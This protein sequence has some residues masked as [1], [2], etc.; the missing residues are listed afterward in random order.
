MSQT[1]AIGQYLS[2]T[3]NS[4]GYFF[5]NFYVGKEALYD[6]GDGTRTYS[7]LPFGFSGITVSRQGDNIEASLV[8]PNNHLSR[9]WAV[10]A[11]KER[12]VAKVHTMLLPPEDSYGD[13]TQLYFYVGQIAAGGWEATALSLNLNSVIDAVTR[14]MPHRTLNQNMCGPIPISANVRV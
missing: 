11:I 8:F 13:V 10:S 12:W 7:F 9:S 14:G 2:F 3:G 6:D 1:F 5:Q 4:G